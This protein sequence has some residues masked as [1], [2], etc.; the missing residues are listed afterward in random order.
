MTTS[1]QQYIDLYQQCTQMILRHSCDVMNA[2]RPKAFD[3]F[4]RLKFPTRKDEKYKYTDI[5]KLFAP[6]Y[7]LNLNRLNIPVNPYEE[8]G[9]AHV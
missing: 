1:E 2:V 5:A 9:R 8:I 6:D 3:D 4:C 7:G